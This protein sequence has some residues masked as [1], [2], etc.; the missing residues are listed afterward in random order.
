MNCQELE[1]IVT[2]LARHSALE[3]E[4]RE[5]GLAHLAQCRECADLLEAQRGLTRE[6]SDWGAADKEMQAP[7]RLEGELRAAFRRQAAAARPRRWVR[8]AVAGSIAAGVLLLF[9]FLTPATPPVEVVKAPAPAASA[10]IEAPPARP[11]AV[12]EPPRPAPRPVRR[13]R[14]PVARLRP[15]PQE[16][17]TEFLPVAQGDGWTPLD[18]GRLMR[19]RLPRSVMGAFGL[20]VDP[21]HDLERVQA[22]VMLSDDGLLRAIRFVR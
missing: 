5:R 16:L 17:G 7:P 9:R 8:F 18:G 3:A 2:D 11:V 21:G 19:V 1:S 22:D 20:P 10:E 6:L 15:V 12:L 13:R 14:I 4:V